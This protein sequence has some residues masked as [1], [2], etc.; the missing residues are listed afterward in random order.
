ML[1]HVAIRAPPG[2]GPRPAGLAAADYLDRGPPGP[3]GAGAGGTRAGDRLPRGPT[4]GRGPGPRGP[5]PGADPTRREALHRPRVMYPSP[6]WFRHMAQADG[7]PRRHREFRHLKS[8]VLDP[9]TH[10]LKPHASPTI[11]D[12]RV[13]DEFLYH[14]DLA[15]AVGLHD[16][17]A[18]TPAPPL[19]QPTLTG[20]GTV[21]P[22]FSWGTRPHGH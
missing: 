3:D 5:G 20:S 2:P 6:M 7:P 4:G 8:P 16:V 18:P 12:R 14:D 19:P 1:L 10:A 15:D 17:H 9:S 13:F 21:G 11:A 22:T